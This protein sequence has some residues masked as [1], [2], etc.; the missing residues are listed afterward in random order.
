MKTIINISDTSYARASIFHNVTYTANN[1]FTNLTYKHTQGHNEQNVGML[2]ETNKIFEV[3]NTTQST[4]ILLFNI[5][6][7]AF[8]IWRP[9]LRSK[10]PNQLFMHLQVGVVVVFC[11]QIVLILVPLMNII[12]T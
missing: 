3:I 12:S 5:L 2:T 8:I 11:H 1:N 10:I 7:F 4:L 9:V 6:L